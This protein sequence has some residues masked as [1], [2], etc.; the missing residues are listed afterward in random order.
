[1]RF[2]EHTI[3][4]SLAELGDYATFREISHHTGL[5]PWVVWGRL[6]RLDGFV[7]PVDLVRTNHNGGSK[8]YHLTGK[9]QAYAEM[10]FQQ[11]CR[12]GG[13]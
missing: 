8:L 13:Q 5:P 3:L 1:M 12:R 2:V 7:E 11:V 6:C 9:G 4:K 10:N